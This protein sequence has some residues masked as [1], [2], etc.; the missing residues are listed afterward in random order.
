MQLQPKRLLPFLTDEFLNKGIDE[1]RKGSIFIRCDC[2]KITLNKFNEDELNILKERVKTIY[3]HLLVKYDKLVLPLSNNIELLGKEENDPFVQ[4]KVIENIE[5][6][7]G[8]N[9]QSEKH[10]K[11]CLSI[12]QH[13]IDLDILQVN[14]SNQTNSMKP[15]EQIKQIESIESIESTEQ[16][17]N[18]EKENKNESKQNIIESGAGSAMLSAYYSLIP[19]TINTSI[20]LIDRMTGLRKKFDRFSKLKGDELIRIPAD[21]G[22]VDPI[23]LIEETEK[24]S[25]SKSTEYSTS[26]IGKHLCG[27]ATDMALR[28]SVSLAKKQLL[29]GIGIALCCHFKGDGHD[30][31][32]ID[33][34]NSLGVRITEI[35]LI[36]RM[37]SWYVA[38]NENEKN[39]EEENEHEMIEEKVQNEKVMTEKE[40]EEQ[41][42]IMKEKQEIG[43]MCR[44]IL[45]VA[46]AVWLEQ[47]ENID[48]V[49]FIK[50]CHKATS[51]ENVLL[52]AKAKF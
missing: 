27:S 47:Q 14:S 43:E 13:L 48:S 49:G 23:Q 38:L 37:A 22:N 19:H 36:H 5:M 21:L 20:Y 35:T 8:W 2:A 52:W 15:N 16:K 12:I 9:F 31:V 30:D 44:I 28:L 18:E 10:T 1:A 34:F 32:A 39:D 40:K 42:R 24:N 6:P 29:R 41:K 51:L 45:N 50:Y 7:H 26:V 33:F 17:E 46:R 25:Q 3:N 4:E 11:Q